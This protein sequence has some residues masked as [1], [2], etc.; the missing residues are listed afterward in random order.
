M[1]KILTIAHREF[2][3]M[4]ATKAFL[5]SLVLMPVLMGGGIVAAA[6]LGRV[7]ETSTKT[8]V[9]VDGTSGGAA[10][11]ALEKAAA[12]HNAFI[13]AAAQ[14]SSKA[15]P[16][17]AN[18]GPFGQGALTKIVLERAPQTS[19]TDESRLELSNRSRKG[20]IDGFAELPADLFSTATD[21]RPLVQFHSQHSP[22]ADSRQWLERTLNEVVRSERLRSLSIDPDLVRRA[23]A[24]VELKS[25]G[26][27]E[28][29]STGGV[30]KP[31]REASEMRSIFLPFGLM[32]LMFMV[33]MMTAQPALETVL[34]E[35]GNRIAELLL[36][37]AS[38]F[39][40]MVGKLLG[41][42]AGS[43]CI[44][45]VYLG[46]GM[47]VLWY[48]EWFDFVPWSLVPWFVAYQV[49]AVLFYNA[50]FLAIGASVNQLKEAQSLLLPVWLLLAL[51]MFVWFNLVR[52]PNGKLATWLSFF[53][54][55]TPLVMTLRLG[56]QTGT[57]LWQ[58]IA[59]FVVMLLAT[60]VGVYIAGRIFRV[61]ILW[62]GAAPKLRDLAKWAISG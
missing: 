50:I 2:S 30:A 17:P 4:V 27:S 15:G 54:P 20:D 22:L 37:S 9:I 45:S 42:V 49:L 23:T 40:L 16:A 24:P 29:A 55:A 8:L 41:T 31:A 48:K 46:G 3:A 14:A 56:T 61:G 12:A 33:I 53:P 43:V 62:Q 7:A 35:K 44:L 6:L 52:E 39:Q 47:A 38:P 28:A 36:G 51:P 19:L 13:D 32:M 60:L 10:V 34:E 18:K 25:F 26:L 11:A 59:G 5:L 58:P 1:H 57:P 21:V